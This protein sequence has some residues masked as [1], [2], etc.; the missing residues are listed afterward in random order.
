MDARLMFAA[1]L[2]LAVVSSFAYGDDARPL[3]REQVRAD[4]RQAVASKTLPNHEYDFG[5]RE[6]KGTSTRARAEVIADMSAARKANTL[7]GPMRDRTYNPGGTETL[8][9]P[10]MTRSEVKAD[11]AA[12]MH[13]GNLRRSDYDDVPVTISRRAARERAAQGRAVAAAR[14]G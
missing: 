14:A 10:T 8:R 2:A 5:A 12:A 7:V 11:V 4:Y 1:T 9:P 13:D 3:S 6:F